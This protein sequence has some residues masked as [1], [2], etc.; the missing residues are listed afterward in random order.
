MRGCRMGLWNFLF[1][2][3]VGGIGGS[4]REERSEVALREALAE[5]ER[6]GRVQELGRIQRERLSVIAENSLVASEMLARSLRAFREADSA[7]PFRRVEGA[8]TTQEEKA[9]DGA[10]G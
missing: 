9:D 6:L 4:F 1:G 7:M 5:I 2:T 8:L 10:E 3:G